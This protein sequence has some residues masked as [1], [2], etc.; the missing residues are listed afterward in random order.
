M[1]QAEREVKWAQPSWER[2]RIVPRKSPRKGAARRDPMFKTSGRLLVTPYQIGRNLRVA[3]L[4]GEDGFGDSVFEEVRIYPEGG[5]VSARP[6][7]I[8]RSMPEAR[9]AIDAIY[10]RYK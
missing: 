10:R 6:R 4:E 9:R 2:I 3:I 1:A 8:Y 5:I 7:V